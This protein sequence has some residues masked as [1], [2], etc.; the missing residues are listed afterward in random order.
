MGTELLIVL[1]SP[2]HCNKV[3]CFVQPGPKT[4]LITT[5][6]DTKQTT[7]VTSFPDDMCQMNWWYHIDIQA[8][9]LYN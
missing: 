8:S 6:H 9:F 5:Q 2:N 3:F 1:S 7:I 4:P